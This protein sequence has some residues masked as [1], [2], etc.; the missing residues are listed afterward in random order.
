MKKLIKIGLILISSVLLVGCSNQEE[1]TTEIPTYSYDTSKASEPYVLEND[2]IKFTLDPAT[3]YFEVL[4]KTSKSVWKSNP[5]DAANNPIADQTNANNAQSTL[6]L[7]YTNNIGVT[8]IYNNFEKSI[9]KH[10]YQIT[11]ND[12]SIQVDYT[13]GD[14]KK[15]YYIPPALPESRMNVYLEK[16]DSG[17]QRKVKSYYR[18]IDLNKLRPTDNKDELLLKYPELENENVYELRSDVQN[19]MKEQMQDFFAQAGYTMEDYEADM[20]KYASKSEEE[21]PYF[22]ISI[23]Y[24]LDGDDIVVEVP[25]D[26][27]LW[28]DEYPITKLEVLPYFGAGSTDDNGYLM[29]PEGNGAVINFNNGRSEQNPYYADVY[30]WDL[31]EARDSMTD[32]NDT[33]FPVFGI[34]KNGSSM[35]CILEDYASVAII[36]ADVSGDGNGYNY[37]HASYNTVHYAKLKV[38]DKTDKSVVMFENK[39]PTGTLKQRYRFVDSDNYINMAQSYR[40]YLMD[41]Y[42]QL[43]KKEETG[44]PVNV[45]I[46]G[47][48]D[49]DVQKFGIPVSEP[50]ELTSYKEAYQMIDE[51]KES[52]YK[53]LSV[54]Y[55]GWMNEGIKPTAIKKIKTVKKL[56]RKKDLKNLINHA[57]ELGI[58][59]YLDATVQTVYDDGLFDGFVVRRDAVRTAGREVLKL[60][61]FTIYYGPKDWFDCYYLVKPHKAIENMEKIAGYAKSNSANIAFSDIGYTV[62][63]SYNPRNLITRE[64]VLKMQLKELE[65]IS[66]DGTGIIVNNGND[67]TLPYA[68]VITDMD[69]FGY[70]YDIIDY[71][72]PFYTAAIHG[73]IDYTGESVNLS[74]NYQNMILK[75]A[76]SG[77][78]LAFTFI[79]E[80]SSQLQETNYTELYGADYDEW[81]QEAYDIYSRYESELG[82]V[83]NQYITDHQRLSDGVFVTTY[84]DGTRVYVNY[85]YD[86]FEQ[87]GIKVPAKDYVVER[88]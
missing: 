29:V 34:A 49:K 80:S 69:L 37:A 28:K 79:K 70:R 51:L 35:L 15:I 11:K 21:Q 4:D 18:R 76:E 20:A 31:G 40:D 17:A 63:G 30:G 73:L 8:V 84:E 77:A 12:D 5:D 39:K 26:K 19:H 54:K 25:Y 78:G 9:Q 74:S 60:Y 23:V 55:R 62:S 32:E 67:Y 52:G 44:T 38:S 86:D 61:E 41:K 56:G 72:I 58:P 45:T 10:N 50:F 75:S 3:T 1:N 57:N 64:E 87:N 48:I 36:E 33:A 65:K 2:K 7:E 88:R 24:R 43:V 13:I 85:N 59:L 66:A 83:F 71:M 6:I 14:F 47:A 22:D 16:M 82:H 53:N 27:M 42:P 46:V 81:K 68:D